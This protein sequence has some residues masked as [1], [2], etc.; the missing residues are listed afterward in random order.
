MKYKFDEMSENHPGF[1][2]FMSYMEST[3]VW[4]AVEGRPGIERQAL[5]LVVAYF[6]EAG[7]KEAYAAATLADKSESIS[8]DKER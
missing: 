6:F 7:I 2:K 1:L 8:M 3:A 5:L 4:K